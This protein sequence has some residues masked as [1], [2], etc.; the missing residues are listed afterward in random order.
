MVARRAGARRAGRSP[1][2]PQGRP[3]TSVFRVFDRLH[4]LQQ[5]VA[6][7]TL[8][9]ERIELSPRMARQP[10]AEPVEWG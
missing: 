6:G 9:K 1:L 4:R 10:V 2:V 8:L 3:E 7:N 5:R